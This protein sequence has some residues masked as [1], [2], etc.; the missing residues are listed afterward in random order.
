[1]LA[2]KQKIQSSKGTNNAAID[3]KQALGGNGWADGHPGN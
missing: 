1:M 3:D 2:A